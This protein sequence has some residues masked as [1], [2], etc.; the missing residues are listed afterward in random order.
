M[1]RQI[2]NMDVVRRNWT[3]REVLAAG[4][5]ALLGLAGCESLGVSHAPPHPASLTHKAIPAHNT[6][7][8]STPETPITLAFAGD[9]MFGRTVNSHMLATAP[10]D[11]YP[12]TY[13][14]DFLRHFDL[15]IG[16]LECVISRLGTPVPK[17]YTFRGDARAYDRLRTAGFDLVSRQQPQWGLWQSCLPRRI[18]H[19]SYTQPDPH[20]RWSEQAAG[21]YTHLQ[22]RARNHD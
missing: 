14:A 13:T 18:P 15:T 7:P 17:A 11:R 21:P 3:R 10:N 4:G 9:V 2:D 12:F 8:T 22:N 1:K 6:S 5:V 16:N 19:P 20:R